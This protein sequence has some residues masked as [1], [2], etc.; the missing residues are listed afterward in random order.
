MSS[1]LVLSL[2]DFSQP[3]VLEFDSQGN[4]IGVFLMKNKHPTAYES[5]KLK[6]HKRLYLVYDKEMISILH[7]LVKLKQYLVGS[8]FIIKI[9]HNSLTNIL[10]YK[11]LND[12]KQKW[13]SNIQAFDFDIEYKKGK[14]NVVVDVLSRKPII[15]LMK[16]H[17]DWK[18]R[19]GVEYA[20]N[21][22][23]C[24]LFDGIIHDDAFKILNDIIYH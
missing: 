14:M 4:G 15:S 12:I 19:L 20:N 13:V 2:P 21:Q 1:C 17:D 7:V 24:D 9:D 23:A 6:P 8:K 10:S 18:S 22:F 16:F 11:E 5:Q 3:F